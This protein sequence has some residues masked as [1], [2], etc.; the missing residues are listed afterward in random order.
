MLR[1]FVSAVAAVL[2]LALPASAQ[3]LE[4]MAGQMIV[5][6]FV[7]DDADDRGVVA[8]REEIAA[9]L[10]GGVMYLKSNVASLRRVEA[11]N[12]GFL[13]ASPAL[14]PLITIDQEGG[15]VERLTRAVGFREIPSA[16]RV[17]TSSTPA[18]SER[19]YADLA[20]RIAAAGFTV[21]F[22]PVVDLKLNPRNQVVARWGRTFGRDPQ[23]VTAYAEAFVRG[24]RA[25]GVLTAL[26]HFPGHG[27]SAGDSH[28][29]Y[30]D[31]TQSWR[32]EE[33]EPYRAMIADGLVDL[34]MIAHLVHRDFATTPSSLT[35]EWIDGVLRSQLGYTGAV[36]SDD[37]EMGA[38]RQHFDL[39]ETVVR[40]VRAGTD[41]LLF[42]NTV[43]PR[44]GLAGEIRAI[45]VAEAEADPAFR[46]RI[47]QSYG[48]I[49]AL[50]RGLAE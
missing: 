23:T 10:V 40:A 7:G 47:E 2:L 50:R 25:A 9:G 5:V 8:L 43:K 39:R 6:G 14:P 29:G 38:I 41:L 32:P 13:S 37:L 45:L 28:E 46:A 20:E 33:L 1:P 15:S 17:A 42:S 3:S 16:E 34:V 35:P 48:R 24:H 44:A 49:V 30:V 12:A 11:M 21:N 4:Q 36:I 19:V 18:E 27:S 31:I 26:K 22:G